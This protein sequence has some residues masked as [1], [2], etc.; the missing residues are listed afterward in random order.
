MPR[1]PTE[2]TNGAPRCSTSTLGRMLKERL[3]HPN[4][5]IGS[6]LYV[7]GEDAASWADV[8]KIVGKVK[9]LVP[10]LVPYAM[11]SATIGLSKDG[12][13]IWV[14][15]AMV[16]P[17]ITGC[18]WFNGLPGPKPG[19]VV[20]CDT[21]GAAAL[22]IERMEKWGLPMDRVKVPFPDDPLQPIDLND[23]TH[24]ERIFNVVCRYKAPL[25]VVDSFRGAHGGDENSSR[26]QR[27][28][29]NLTKI[30]EETK[31]ASHVIHHVGKPK[32]EEIGMHSARGSSAFLAQV[33]M[34]LALD[35]PDPRPNRREA[36]R[37]VRVLGE[38]LGVSPKPI[39]FR[40]TDTGLEFGP[41]PKPAGKDS[42]KGKAI[43]WLDGQMK[44][45]TW[46]LASE[47]L[48][49][50]EAFG[51]STNAVQRAREGMGITQAAGHCR[52]RD[53]GK[54]EWKKPG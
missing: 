6:K 7:P 47:L 49:D 22:N 48:T 11:T 33:R 30:S 2:S 16:K 12:K 18:K 10:Q 53:D 25:I 9:F 43:E 21:E 38:N 20:W 17:I 50:A 13:S 19:F 1:S 45:D 39:G 44:P 14:L 54:W 42:R 26:I 31:A 36:W 4:V 34:Q 40:I 27:T 52:K 41:A 32:D 37:R 35:I 29:Q 15:G 8:A 51:L 46:H 5:R 3:K 24:L 23:E 28:L